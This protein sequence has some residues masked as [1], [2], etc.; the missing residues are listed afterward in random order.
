MSHIYVPPRV[1]SQAGLNQSG[2]LTYPRAPMYTSLFPR[3]IAKTSEEVC[4]KDQPIT[5]Q[6]QTAHSSW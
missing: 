4:D 2:G 1:V 3:V 5:E 6:I